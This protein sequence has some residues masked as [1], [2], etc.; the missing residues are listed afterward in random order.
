MLFGLCMFHAVIQERKK[1]GP[2]GWNI[3]Y[4]FNDSDREFAFNTLK[5]YCAGG[6]IPW[7]AL[8]YIT[9][10]ITYG[11]RVTDMWDLRCLKTILKLFFAPHTL[12]EGY[13]YCPSGTYYCPQYEKLQDYR[14][15]IETLPLIEQPEIFGMHE[16]ANIAFQVKETQSILRTILESQPRAGG[17]AEG[18]SSDEIVYELADNIRNV[19]M[20]KVE[21]EEPFPALMKVTKLHAHHIEGWFDR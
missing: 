8:E 16:N 17:T 2:L 5:M 10:E 1:F 19:I 3:I 11:G 4:E 12:E 14:D 9:G 15:F 7:D 18:K 6:F 21:N 20:R 13:I